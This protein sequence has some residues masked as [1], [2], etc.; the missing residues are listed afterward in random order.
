MHTRATAMRQRHK[1]VPKNKLRKYAH[2]WRKERAAELLPAQKIPAPSRA[3]IAHWLYDIWNE[4]PT[5]IVRNAYRG[6]GYVFED[7]VNYSYDT[8]TQSEVSSDD[9]YDDLPTDSDSKDSAAELYE[10]EK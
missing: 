10:T 1:Y 5:E 6:C 2:E 4:F 3:N 8:E 9:D 7:D